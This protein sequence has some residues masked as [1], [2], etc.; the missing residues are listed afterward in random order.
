MAHNKN[1]MENKTEQIREFELMLN[2][3]KLK[4][5]SNTSLKRPLSDSEFNEM[6]ILKRELLNNKEVLEDE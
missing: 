6:M 3:S 5:L 2:T 1:K 4:A